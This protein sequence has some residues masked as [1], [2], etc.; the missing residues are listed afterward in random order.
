MLKEE[1]VIKIPSVEVTLCCLKVTAGGDQYAAC[2]SY[3]GNLKV[4][5]KDGKVINI[6][7]E[8]AVR[9]TEGHC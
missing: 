3:K 6:P 2:S 5:A 9:L 7:S 1:K 4:T 8:A